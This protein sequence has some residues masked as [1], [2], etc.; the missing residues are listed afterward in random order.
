MLDIIINYFTNLQNFGL[1][2]FKRYYGSY[3]GF[4]YSNEDPDNLGRLQLIIP[5]L[6]DTPYKYW[7]LSK[8]IYCGD[9][10]GSFVLPNK[11]DPVWVEFENGDC[12]F[13]IWNYGW[14]IPKNVPEGASPKVKVFQTTSGNRIEF[15]DDTNLISIIQGTKKYTIKLSENG[16]SLGSESES[17]EKSVL[18]ETLKEKLEN[19]IDKINDVCTGIGVLTVP[20]AL[21]VSGVP[22][23]KLTFDNAKVSLTQIKGELSS[24]LSENVSL[25]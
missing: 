18:G 9:Q 24:I 3:K 21:G 20:T 5:Q 23:N 25:D 2:Y 16:I 12:R 10:I 6:Y 8:G 17:K 19:L 22:I 11:S 7:A 14:W 1:E 15:N 4:V 13:P